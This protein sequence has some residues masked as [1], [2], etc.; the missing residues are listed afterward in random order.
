MAF[1]AG[2]PGPV[3]AVARAGVSAFLGLT[4]DDRPTWH[5]AA[6]TSATLAVCTDRAAYRQA[7]AALTALGQPATRQQTARFAWDLW[8]QRA[9]NAVLAYQGDRVTD[10]W[11][12]AHIQIDGRPPTGGAILVSVHHT[13]QLLGFVRMQSVIEQ[14]GVIGMFE[15][16]DHPAV[17]ATQ[18]PPL[19][20]PWRMDES[21]RRLMLSRLLRRIFGPR[22]FAPFAALRPGLQLLRDGGSLI[23]LPDHYERGTRATLL[24]RQISVA[25]GAVVLSQR[26]G[27][28]IV[29]CGLIP[30]PGRRFRLWFGEPLAV[31]QAA[32]VQ[33]LEDCVRRAP[34][35]WIGWGD[36]YRSPR[37]PA[38]GECD[39]AGA[40]AA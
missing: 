29:P 27:R 9:S 15:P 26:T 12:A 33:A 19:P 23:L 38:P 40:T 8:Y 36:W 3:Q 1:Q 2:L 16:T 30:L 22:L 37:A 18:P 31:S 6:A 17:T 28:P 35:A 7:R 10:A 4:P 34:E 11:A 24:G 39:A 32:V 20:R 14:L 13:N 5:M 25:E 21:Y